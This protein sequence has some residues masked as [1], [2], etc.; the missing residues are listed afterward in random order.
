[1]A[2]AIGLFFE[3]IANRKASLVVGCFNQRSQAAASP[4]RA[5][6]DLAGTAVLLHASEAALSRPASSKTGL[7]S[8]CNSFEHARSVSVSH[9]ALRAISWLSNETR[10]PNDGNT[11]WTSKPAS[12]GAH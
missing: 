11:A 5:A 4:S 7:Q 12:S 8:C 9:A 1:M 2:I 3:S 10:A 6:V